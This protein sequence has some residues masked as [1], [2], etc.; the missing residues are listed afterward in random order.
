MRF[1]WPWCGNLR[2]AVAGGGDGRTTRLSGT[3][4][5]NADRNGE[6][7]SGRTRPLVYDAAGVNTQSVIDDWNSAPET[8]PCRF[9][10]G[11]AIEMV[12][13]DRLCGTPIQTGI[14]RG[15]LTKATI[16]LNLAAAARASSGTK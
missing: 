8:H 4:A 1:S 9:G 16:K 15:R 2:R 11:A 6:R 3:L 5:H 12:V 10:P 14:D 7:P 13:D